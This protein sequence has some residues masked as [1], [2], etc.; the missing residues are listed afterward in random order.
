[1]NDAIHNSALPPRNTPKPTLRFDTAAFMGLDMAQHEIDDDIFFVVRGRLKG[2]R[3]SEMEKGE[4]GV[5][6]IVL[7]IQD[8]TPRK[9]RDE[10]NRLT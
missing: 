4:L 3:S 2:K 9:E 8:Q 6:I 7:D 10:T 1:M 5:E